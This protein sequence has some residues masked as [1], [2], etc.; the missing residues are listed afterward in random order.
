M[1]NSGSD[2]GDLIAGLRAR[3]PRAMET[4]YEQFGRRAF[5]LAYRILGNGQAAEDAVQDAFIALWNQVDRLDSSRGQ[6]GS[7]LMTIVHRRSIDILRSQRGMSVRIQP[8][9]PDTVDAAASDVLDAVS[10]ALT[11]EAVREALQSLPPEQRRVIELAY[12]EGMT[13]GEI[14]E[15]TS[16]PLGTVKSRL[17]LALT[18][19]RSE[20]HV[21]DAE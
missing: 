19:L 1:R 16:V 13:Q 4:L 21:G 5:G 10:D 2:L 17:R 14:A 6:V 9:E 11:F 15:E 18:R 12:F 20:L 3:D 7:L 8:L